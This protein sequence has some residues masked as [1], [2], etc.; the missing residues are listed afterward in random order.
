MTL[1]VVPCL[2]IGAAVMG[3]HLPCGVSLAP[4]GARIRVV[5]AMLPASTNLC[6]VTIDPLTKEIVCFPTPWIWPGPCGFLWLLGW[7]VSNIS[8]TGS[9]RL[10]DSAPSF[11]FLHHAERTCLGQTAEG[12]AA[13][14]QMGEHLAW[15]FRTQELATVGTSPVAG[16]CW[17]CP[18]PSRGLC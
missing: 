9:N 6:H 8:Q 3:V 18:G 16:A 12:F 13:S 10:H 17:L 5:F 4:V 7:L 14:G 1:L 2:Y 15:F 11:L